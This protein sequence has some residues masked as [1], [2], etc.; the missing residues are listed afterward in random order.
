MHLTPIGSILAV[1]GSICDVSDRFET[2]D[3]SQG[4]LATVDV[5]RQDLPGSARI[6]VV[7]M[8]SRNLFRW[9]LLTSSHSAARPNVRLHKTHPDSPRLFLCRAFPHKRNPLRTE[10][11]AA[12]L[13]TLR[14]PTGH[15]VT[16][17]SPWHSSSTSSLPSSP[18]RPPS[19]CSPILRTRR[20]CY[21]RKF[22]WR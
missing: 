19:S 10:N 11:M 8:D 4:Q 7:D 22:Q 20:P 2:L 15:V 14:H 6:H 1:L 5:A 18:S 13:V 16:C 3:V 9:C 21:V 12:F 17:S